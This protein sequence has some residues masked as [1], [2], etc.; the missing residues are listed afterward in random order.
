[1]ASG[2]EINPFI[3]LIKC[4]SA[5]IGPVLI[6]DPISLHQSALPESTNNGEL[7]AHFTAFEYGG[8]RVG[9][10]SP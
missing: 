6:A 1:V 9:C 7:G 2:V 5:P 10:S 3:V 4:L 8:G